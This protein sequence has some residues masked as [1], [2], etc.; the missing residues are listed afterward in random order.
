MA[1][2]AALFMKPQGLIEFDTMFPEESESTVRTRLETY[3]AEGNLKAAEAS[4][5]S[6]DL[7][8]AAW[9]YYR[10]FFA[11]F[12]GLSATPSSAAMADQGST[13]YTSYQIQNFKA[14]S[15]AYLAE[16]QGYVSAIV[17]PGNL[18]RSYSVPHTISY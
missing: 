9:V 7:A 2:V 12:V 18:L 8:V 5:E 6:I 14:L 10:A 15:D 13:V 1:L 17:N 3:I 16:F 11:V 4:S